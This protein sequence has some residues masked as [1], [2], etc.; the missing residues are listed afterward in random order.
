[1]RILLN[2]IQS[3]PAALFLF[4][5]LFF[6]GLIVW[7]FLLGY[8][9]KGRRRIL[10]L[11]LSFLPAMVIM[12]AFTLEIVY[13]NKPIPPSYISSTIKYHVTYYV[14]P[15]VI[16]YTAGFISTILRKSLD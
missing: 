12:G 3:A 8:F 10:G 9:L 5:W 6:T 4:L 14:L 16:G 13:S 11:L 7:S 2:P 1:V 15:S